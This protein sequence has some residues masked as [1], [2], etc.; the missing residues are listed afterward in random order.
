MATKAV[1]T[2]RSAEGP[3][4]AAQIPGASAAIEELTKKVIA[5][6]EQEQSKRT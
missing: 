4:C 3:S 1:F 2:V 5:R 6:H